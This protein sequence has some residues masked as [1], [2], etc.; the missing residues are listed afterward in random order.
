MY[1]IVG[2]CKRGSK[3]YPGRMYRIVPE[4]EWGDPQFQVHAVILNVNN[5]GFV[6]LHTESKTVYSVVPTTRDQKDI[7]YFRGRFYPDT[8]LE[9]ICWRR[10]GRLKSRDTEKVIEVFSKA[11]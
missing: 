5:F 10:K 6:L 8:I 11:L 9:D 2:F 3:Q 1:S 4:E 7:T